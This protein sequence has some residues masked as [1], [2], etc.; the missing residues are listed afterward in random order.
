MCSDSLVN[1]VRT[2][3]TA[4]PIRFSLLSVSQI[5]YFCTLRD[6]LISLFYAGQCP[7]FTPAFG[8]VGPESPDNIQS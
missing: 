5:N 6:D 3:A 1:I 7:I 4:S 2:W 8:V